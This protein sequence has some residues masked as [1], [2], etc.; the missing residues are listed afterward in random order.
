MK[1][2]RLN[3][4]DFPTYET[5]EKSAQGEAQALGLSGALES[6]ACLTEL[7]PSGVA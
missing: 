3:R 2:R 1:N 6:N 4:G 7:E 5:G